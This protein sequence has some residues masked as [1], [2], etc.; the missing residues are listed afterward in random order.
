MEIAQYGAWKSPIYAQ[1]LV[2]DSVELKQIE[3]DGDELYWLEGR[4]LEGGRYVF[5]NFNTKEDLFKDPFYARTLVHEYGGRCSIIKDGVL[6]FCNYK[7]QNI[8]KVEGGNS[9]KAITKTS[10]KRFGDLTIHPNG[11]WIYCVMEDHADAK[12][13]INSI[14]KIDIDSGSIEQISNNHD[15]YMSPKISSNGNKLIYIFWD[16]PNMPWDGTELWEASLNDNGTINK[17]KKIAGGINES[18][19]EPLWSQD[20]KLFFI[21][22]RN[23]YWNIY[24]ENNE[25]VIE[26]KGDFA[27]PPWLLGNRSYTFININ[28]KPHIAA[29]ITEKATDSLI[30]IDLKTKIF[31][32]ESLKFTQISEIHTREDSLI[33]IASSPTTLK[34]IIEYHPKTKSYKVL[35]KSKELNI[36][37]EFFSIPQTV[38]YQ[39]ED[40]KNAFAFFYPPTNPNYKNNRD[41]NKPPLIVFVH[42][43]P[44]SHVAPDCKIGILYFTSRGFAVAAVNYGGSTGYG[45]EY[46][47]RL[48]G[49]WGVVDLDDCCNCAKYLVK[50]KMVDENRLAIRGGSAGGYTTLSAITFRNTFNVGTSLFGVSDLELLVKETHK[51]ESLYLESLIGPYQQAKERYHALS[52]IYNVDKIKCPILLL[53]GEEDKVVLPNQA[54]MMYNALIKNKIPTAYLLFKGEQHGF[55][56]SE[57]IIRA[58]TAE[59]YFYCKIF[60]IKIVEEI[61]P[62]DILID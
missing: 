4:P 55:R 29:I 30:L 13:I 16:H 61:E 50:N 51:F 40:G 25:P 43:G 32:K 34:E 8:Y 33:F 39:T 49:A 41:D 26:M 15:F 24:D 10:E 12:N 45:R 53:Q 3:I 9:P 6:Y 52:P 1:S 21:S 46:R 47:D 2:S 35:V 48:K 20:D 22:D 28:K 23:G 38:E 62:I 7:D 60:N 19:L 58:T 37:K 42:G 17:E 54:E 31:T 27:A 44:T 14:V 57:N 18:V 11:K 56:K 5:V 36:D 59:Y